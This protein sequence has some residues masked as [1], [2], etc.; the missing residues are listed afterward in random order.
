MNYIIK[1]SLLVSA[2]SLM[3]TSAFAQ[4]NNEPHFY[5]GIAYERASVKKIPQSPTVSLHTGVIRGGY[6]FSQ[7]FGAEA[8]IGTGIKGKK[9]TIKDATVKYKAGLTAGIYGVGFLPLSDKFD[10]IA[11]A[12]Y[13][14]LKITGESKLFDKKKS[15][16]DSGFAWSVGAQYFITESQ[17]I[18]FDYGKPSKNAT[19]ISLGYVA[20][21]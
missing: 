18:R 6:R 21:F 20:R 17:G 12:G 10:L 15:F 7:Y 14:T 9:I 5:G 3:A 8:E 13:K 16:K 2:T 1:A 11:R 19:V 4:S